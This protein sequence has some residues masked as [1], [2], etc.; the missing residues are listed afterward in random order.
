MCTSNILKNFFTL[1][2]LKIHKAHSKFLAVA[3]DAL[4]SGARLTC[5]SLG[6]N[7]K[8]ETTAKHNIKRVD[9]NLSNPNL[10]SARTPISGALIQFFLVNREKPLIAIDWSPSNRTQQCHILRATLI[11]RKH[12]RGITLYEEVHPVK[13]LGNAKIHEAF[14]KKL[15]EMAPRKC[16]PIIIT[17]AGFLVP[18]LKM[19]S[20]I[21]WDYVGRVRGTY[22]YKDS[23]NSHWC[24]I[25]EL[26]KK[27]S[28]KA[29]FIKD[30]QLSKNA[31]WNCSAVL[32]KKKVKG[33]KQK[34]S[35]GKISKA[36]ASRE[37][38][39]RAREP[40][41]LVSSLTQQEYTAE[42]IANIYQKRMQIEENFRDTKSHAFGMGMKTHRSKSPKRTEILLLIG[43]LAHFIAYALGLSATKLGINKN[44]QANTENRYQVLSYAFLGLQLY[45]S[46]LKEFLFA[47]ITLPE[48]FLTIREPMDVIS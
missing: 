19:V 26:F 45:K 34:G 38:A 30:F 41:L 35:K 4:L 25:K 8:T 2:K 23:K 37:H 22:L 21:G 7:I 12:G 42:Q 46:K 32:V 24:S 18:W 33:R 11:I 48:L 13:K 14:L 27:A 16:K 29:T 20:S 36:K 39:V 1:N 31:E 17:D 43:M 10:H 28:T 9:N 5:T 40:W 6:R 47:R 3:I 15:K 44:F